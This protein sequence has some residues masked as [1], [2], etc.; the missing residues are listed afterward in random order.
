[1]PIHGPARAIAAGLA[2]VPEDRQRHGLL[3]SMTLWFN[4]CLT[5]LG[6][7]ARLGW[8]N[9]VSEG[10][11]A[12]E[13]IRDLGVRATGAYQVVRNL[14]GGNQQKVVL[15]KWLA[16]KPKVLILDEPT[17]GID[18]GAKS[19]IYRLISD[20]AKTGV[21]VM[22]ISSEM[23][24][25]VGISDRVI[26]MREGQIAGELQ[27]GEINEEAVL[28]LAIGVSNKTDEDGP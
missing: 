22:M 16:T 2:L 1:M 3:L 19:D 15:G 7:L 6:R 21:A 10:G 17:R 8:R 13:M 12:Q 20:L 11:L 24:E 26:V 23:E 28:A 27:R 14:S 25:I 4:I 9:R 18:I 5:V